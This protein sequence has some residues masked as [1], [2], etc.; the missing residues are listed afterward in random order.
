MRRS[1]LEVDVAI[2]QALSEAKNLKLTHIMYKANVNS[3]FLK[4]KLTALE[5]K[6]LVK[7][8]RLQKAGIRAPDKEH[9][10]YSITEEGRNI[11]RS[12]MSIHN[13]LG[14]AE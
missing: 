9:R 12:Y 1:S 10:F 2:L 4:P 13:V 11:L 6:G 14:S 8:L 7:V 5:E 3:F